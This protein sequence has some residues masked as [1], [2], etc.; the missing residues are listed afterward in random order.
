MYGV[1]CDWTSDG[2]ACVER[3]REAK[4]HTYDAI[5]MDMQMPNMNGLEAT[6]A[7]R[8]MPLPEAH[9]IPILALTAN[10]FQEDVQRCI[11]AGMNAY[12]SKPV[13]VNKLMTALCCIREQRD[14]PQT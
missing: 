13:D 12:L 6:V 3:F 4:P 9:S 5:L 7:I 14:I 2:A 10:A 1:A 11:N 8:R